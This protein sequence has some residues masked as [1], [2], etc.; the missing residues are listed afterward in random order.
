MY[1]IFNGVM[2]TNDKQTCSFLLQPPSVIKVTFL[3]HWLLRFS[4]SLSCLHHP[5]SSYF[6]GARCWHKPFTR[7]L[8]Q[9][10]LFR[11]AVLYVRNRHRIRGPHGSQSYLPSV[12][13]IKPGGGQSD[14][15]VQGNAGIAGQQCDVVI[16]ETC[17]RGGFDLV[18]KS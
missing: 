15:Y 7:R 5:F 14:V 10:P 2:R 13:V 16:H 11:L 1:K 17:C 9:A 4:S 6:T 8:L 12:A 18:K 3:R